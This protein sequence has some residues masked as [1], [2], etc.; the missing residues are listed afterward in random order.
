MWVSGETPADRR[1]SSS[2]TSVSYPRS[3]AVPHMSDSSSAPGKGYS[4]RG[5]RVGGDTVRNAAPTP[6]AR[7]DIDTRKYVASRPDTRT[8]HMFR[9]PTRSLATHL[10]G[11][12]LIFEFIALHLAV[13]GACVHRHEP[14]SQ[15][16]LHARASSPHIVH[17]GRAQKRMIRPGWHAAGRRRTRI[18]ARRRGTSSEWARL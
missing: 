1:C 17:P 18:R 2:S 3:P 9:V 12:A 5:S 13:D 15:H 11:V 4:V 16:H 6:T 10:T 7:S 14:E 8:E